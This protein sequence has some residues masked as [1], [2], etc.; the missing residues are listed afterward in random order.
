MSAQELKAGFSAHLTRL[1]NL[2]VGS[3]LPG[4]NENTR[5][6]AAKWSKM[7]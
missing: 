4:I 6:P 3:P 1:G 5:S 2:F 7:P